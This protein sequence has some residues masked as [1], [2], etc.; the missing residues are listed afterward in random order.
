MRYKSRLRKKGLAKKKKKRT[1]TESLAGEV[2]HQAA[3]GVIPLSGGSEGIGLRANRDAI[4]I[5]TLVVGLT[6]LPQTAQIKNVV[7]VAALI[8]WVREDV[9]R[10]AVNVVEHVLGWRRV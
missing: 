5:A 6:R 8:G 7:G 1:L 9:E 2:A 3:G 4:L 10:G